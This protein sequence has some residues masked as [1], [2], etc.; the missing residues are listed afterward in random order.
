MSEL[1]SLENKDRNKNKLTEIQQEVVDL[2]NEGMTIPQ[3]AA[4]R[5]RTVDVVYKNLE[6]IKKKGYKIEQERSGNQVIRYRV[7]VTEGL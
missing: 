4:K 5:N 7:A 1:E 6:L 2:L 3:I